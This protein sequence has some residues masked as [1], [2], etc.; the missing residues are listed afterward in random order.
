M[1]KLCRQRQIKTLAS[2]NA[3]HT[4]VSVFPGRDSKS[5]PLCFSAFSSLFPSALS[6]PSA[7]W[8]CAG[9]ISEPKVLSGKSLKQQTQFGYIDR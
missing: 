3:N 9:L 6:I 7:S 5:L 1:S 2:A 4:Y 8:Q